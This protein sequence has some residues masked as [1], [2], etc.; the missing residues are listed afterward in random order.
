MKGGKTLG[1]C[2]AVTLLGVFIF[3]VL[4]TMVVEAARQTSPFGQDQIKAWMLGTPQ[5]VNGRESPLGYANAGV[6]VGWYDY[7]HPDDPSEPWGIPFDHKEPLGCEFQDCPNYCRHTGVD[8]PG[9]IGTPILATMSGRVV[10]VGFNGDWGNLVVV[11]N[12]GYQTWYAH[13]DWG[14]FAVSMQQIINRGQKIGERGDNGNSSG[15]HLHYGIK[16]RTGDDS[17]IWVDPENYFDRSD[18]IERDCPVW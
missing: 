10:F 17:Y 15:A 9:N 8:F 7:T 14:S 16:K 13:L 18:T 4:S 6:G 11:E 3:I 2:L 1:C 5:P 12:N